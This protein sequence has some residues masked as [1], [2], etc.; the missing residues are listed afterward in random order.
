M[1]CPSCG[2]EIPDNSR[3]CL[4]CGKSPA[5][6]LKATAPVERKEP[7]EKS[8]TFRNILIG[9]VVVVVALVVISNL[10]TS[11]V[12]GISQREPLTPESFTVPAGQIQYYTFTLTGSGRVVGR[13]EASGGT[14]NDIE[15]VITDADNFENW[16][17]GHQAR[18]MYQSGKTTV[19]NI[20]T[21]LGPGTYYLAFNNGF[22]VVTAKTITSS[23]VLNH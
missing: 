21:L 5:A 22:S 4:V 8:H 18:V 6:T 12:S 10:R 1:F 7:E 17:N 9:V 15:A 16:K 11:G 20:N 23:I 13:F 19:G 2:K 14:G 3:Y